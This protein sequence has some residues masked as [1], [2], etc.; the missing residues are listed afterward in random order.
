MVHP[1][2]GVSLFHHGTT[3]AREIVRARV[4]YDLDPAA[5]TRVLVDEAHRAEHDEGGGD[6]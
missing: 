3:V 1:A 4:V 2:R 5:V 6:E